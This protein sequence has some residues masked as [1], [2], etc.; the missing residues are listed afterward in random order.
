MNSTPFNG[1]NLGLG[2]IMKLSGAMTRSITAEN[3]YGEKGRGGMAEVSDAPQAE[4]TRIGQPWQANYAH[5]RELGRGWAIFSA[6]DGRC[7]P[8]SWRC[9]ST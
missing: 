6:M 2:N 1:T 5:A 8:T 7:V 3:V 9:R 4:V